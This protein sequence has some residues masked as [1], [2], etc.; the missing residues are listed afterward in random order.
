MPPDPRI[1]PSAGDCAPAPSHT[2]GH[3]VFRIR[4]LNP[5]AYLLAASSDG[6]INPYPRGV[7]FKSALYSNQFL[8][9]RH[10]PRRVGTSFSRR[11]P[12]PG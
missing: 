5:A 7:S 10:A 9:V 4:R 8:A 3:T 1:G 11:S 2:T 12:N 6:S